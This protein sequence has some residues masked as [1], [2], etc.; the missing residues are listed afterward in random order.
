MSKPEESP[1]PPWR[2]TRFEIQLYRLVEVSPGN[3]VGEGKCRLRR[4][5]S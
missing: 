3:W 1:P 4:G 2:P 5:L